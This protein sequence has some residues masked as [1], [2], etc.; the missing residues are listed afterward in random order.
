M[1]FLR[2]FVPRLSAA[3]T[4]LTPAS[5]STARFV[6][7]TKSPPTEVTSAGHY[8]AS[9]DESSGRDLPAEQK[10]RENMALQADVISDA[11]REL[12]VVEL[13]RGVAG[14]RDWYSRCPSRRPDRGDQ[15]Q[16]IEAGF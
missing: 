4:S 7:T 15:S 9:G 3:S 1:S 10:K 6:S 2:P 14:P 8:G 13:A 16:D 11:P 12:A 5:I